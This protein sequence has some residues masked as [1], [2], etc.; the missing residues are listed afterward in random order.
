M[1]KENYNITKNPN[2]ITIISKR[3]CN[4]AAYN[5]EVINYGK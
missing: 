1:G 4:F 5:K 3:F 2:N